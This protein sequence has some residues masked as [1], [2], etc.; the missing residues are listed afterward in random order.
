MRFE[1][2]QDIWNNS[3]YPIIYCC[4]EIDTVWFIKYEDWYI[5][6]D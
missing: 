3:Y 6:K 2:Y 4:G 1:I 5:T